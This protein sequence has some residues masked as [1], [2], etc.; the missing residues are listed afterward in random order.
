MRC[1][2]AVQQESLATGRIIERAEEQAR[3]LAILRAFI[4]A[5]T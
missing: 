1:V 2:I 3:I 5:F 4:N